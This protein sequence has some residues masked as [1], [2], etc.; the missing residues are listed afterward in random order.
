[1][2]RAIVTASL[3]ASPAL[4]VSLSGLIMKNGSRLS[5]LGSRLSALGSRPSASFKLRFRRPTP[6]APLAL[7]RRIA[8]PVAILEKRYQVFARKAQQLAQVG[9]R[10]LRFS[11]H[12]LFHA[13]QQFGYRTGRVVA[14]LLAR[15]QAFCALQMP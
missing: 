4:T 10:Q 11:R 1:M 2:R 7:P 5:A 13:A 8:L 6:N 14:G 15:R 3:K 12:A 9:W